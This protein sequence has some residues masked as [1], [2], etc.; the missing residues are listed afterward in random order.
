MASESRGSGRSRLAL[1]LL[2]LIVLITGGCSG[3][4]PTYP[5][6]G[7]VTLDAIPLE[8]G[9][10]VFRPIGNDDAFEV[11]LPVVDGSFAGGPQQG[12]IAG[13]YLILFERYQPELEE[14]DAAKAAGLPSP[15]DAPMIPPRYTE[16]TDL[17][18]TVGPDSGR[19]LVFALT[20][21]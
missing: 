3:E 8:R 18:A 6:D 1:L 20:R 15:L 4:L 10:I 21:S 12:P 11:R 14:V 2:P 5:V 7:T 19:G 13:E 17:R 9:T 16:P